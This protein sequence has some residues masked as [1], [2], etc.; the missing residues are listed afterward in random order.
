MTE[1]RNP[2]LT[3]PTLPRSRYRPRT[4]L[5]MPTIAYCPACDD[6]VVLT[7]SRTCPWC[8]LVI[9]IEPTLDTMR[10]TLDVWTLYHLNRPPTDHR[11]ANP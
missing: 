11:K 2:A 7:R 3:T 9:D 6:T 10:R 8:D 1:H 5:E 4:N